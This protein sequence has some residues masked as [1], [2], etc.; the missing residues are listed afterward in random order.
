VNNQEMMATWT[1]STAHKQLTFKL[2]MASSSTC[3]VVLSK[4]R[5]HGVGIYILATPAVL[6]RLLTTNIHLTAFFFFCAYFLAIC[7]YNFVTFFLAFQNVHPSIFVF[8]RQFSGWK[9]KENNCKQNK[10]TNFTVF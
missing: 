6:T 7:V 5:N 3:F 9:K 10:Q 4:R 8:S 1:H 2:L